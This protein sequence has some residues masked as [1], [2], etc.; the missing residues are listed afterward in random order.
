MGMR[1]FGGGPGRA[2]PG[3]AKTGTRSAPA[4]SGG[5]TYT[6]APKVETQ[7]RTQKETPK[8]ESPKTGGDS[9]AGWT[10]RFQEQNLADAA[11]RRSGGIQAVDPPKDQP[12]GSSATSPDKQ[13]KA[14]QTNWKSQA[15]AG[16]SGN[17]LTQFQSLTDI[18]DWMRADYNWSSSGPPQ[19]LKEAESFLTA[20]QSS[21]A[22]D[23]LT[24]EPGSITDAA[25]VSQEFWDKYQSASNGG[26]TPVYTDMSGN[27][28]K[29]EK[30]ITERRALDNYRDISAGLI[31]DHRQT[32]REMMGNAIQYGYDQ[33][34]QADVLSS[35]K[36]LSELQIS[37]DREMAQ[38]ERELQEKL[39]NKERELMASEGAAER[40]M[41]KDIS[42]AEIT[43]RKDI[44]TLQG[45]QAIDQIKAEG[46]VQMAALR[47]K[48]A[49]TRQNLQT[50]IDAQERAQA[51]DR[52]TAL[53]KIERE[54]QAQKS[55]VTLDSDLEMERASMMQQFQSNEAAKDRALETQNLEEYRRAAMANE[56]IQNDRLQLEREGQSLHLLMSV[57]QNPALLYYMKQ[58]GM[59]SGAGENILGENVETLIGDL[60]ASIDPTNLPNI[61]TYNAMSELEQQIT[62]TSAG[63]TQGMSQEGMQDYL[64]GTSPF[65]RGQ[66][67]SIRIGSDRNPFEA[68]G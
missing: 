53:L 24:I 26:T 56:R 47:E 66:R 5:K 45:T 48:H 22:N 2:G 42:A 41:R 60:S 36:R 58:S 34:L 62:G 61:Q 8:V 3:G 21:A 43:G 37:A 63:A 65:T 39:A 57:S 46:D 7:T 16:L 29:D 44:A 14:S 20:A 50:E 35:N 55:L 59:L 19:S 12:G 25:S 27:F 13:T 6:T 4:K 15:T 38:A 30:L 11:A 49:D 67:S 54:S 33:Q 51:T 9:G 52:D 28:I 18:E 23:L 17:L 64:Q 40:T 32:K 10:S 68:L 31:E 1:N